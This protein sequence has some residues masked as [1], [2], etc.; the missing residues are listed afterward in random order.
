[1]KEVNEYGDDVGRVKGYI[2]DLNSKGGTFL[3]G[4]RIEEE[5]YVELKSGDGLK[6]GQDQDGGEWVVV[7]EEDNGEMKS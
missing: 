4:E 6:F 5:R 3:N 2:L 7:I 1:M